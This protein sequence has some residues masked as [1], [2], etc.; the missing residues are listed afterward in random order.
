MFRTIGSYV[1]TGA[2]VLLCGADAAYAQKQSPAFKVGKDTAPQTLN[3]TLGWFS[4]RGADSRDP[5]DVLTFDQT[6]LNFDISDF[7][8]AQ[9]G[10]EYLLPIGKFVEAGAGVSFSNR[11]VHSTYA[12]F[13]ANDGSE[14]QQQLKMKRV[15]LEFTG[16]VL[17][18]GQGTKWQPYAGAG[19]ALI[20]WHY[21]EEGD[22]VDFDQGGAIFNDTFKDSGTA[23][24][25]VFFGGVRYATDAFS[26]GFEA[27]YHKATGDLDPSQFFPKK[28][29][30]GG[31]IF[32]GTFGLRF[33]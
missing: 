15:P 1:L 5:D 3:F 16:R 10:A 14:I 22:F 7:K 9:F 21:T 23:V 11:S 30:L 8:A 12:D 26:A 29:D 17:P 24:G 31:W 19:L 28:I 20:F 33:D 18:L 27:K 32:Q 6:F 2:L 25:P 13:I 4:P